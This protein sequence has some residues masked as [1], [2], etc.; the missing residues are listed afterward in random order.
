MEQI[1]ENQA[2]FKVDIKQVK[3][4]VDSIRGDMS[5]VLIA[6]KNIIDRQEKIPRVAFEEITQAI[7][8]SSGHQLKKGLETGPQ[9][10]VM[11]Q[12]E[13]RQETEGF[14]PPPPNAG[15]SHTL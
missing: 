8:A 5:Q 10:Y 13:T 6:L 1:E 4:N 14:I 11:A 3:S 12:H 2:T 9:K 7:G 15:A